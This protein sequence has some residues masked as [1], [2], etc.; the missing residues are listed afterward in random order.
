MS[1]LVAME[2]QAERGQHADLQWFYYHM[3][4]ADSTVMSAV[5]RRLAF[6]DSLDWEIRLV[7][8]ADPVLAQEQALALREAYD[9][10]DNLKDAARHLATALFRGYAHLDKYPSGWGRRVAHL[11]PVPQWLWVRRLPDG[12]WLYNP[13][14][15]SCPSRAQP[16]DR[17]TLMIHAA[18]AL[19]RNIARHFFSKTLAFADWDTALENSANQSIFVVGP[20][21]VPAD[22][23]EE[24][25]S[26]AERITSDGRGY[27]PNGSD[28][29]TVDLFARSKLPFLDR[30]DYCDRQIVLAATGGLLTMLTESGSGT[31][32]GGAHS[33]SLMDLARSD[34]ARLSETFQRDL[35]KEVLHAEF[36]HQPV[37]AYFAFDV[38]QQQDPVALLQAIGNLSWQGYRAKLDWLQE[39]TGMQMELMPQPGGQ[40]PAPTDPTQGVSP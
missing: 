27:L 30:I 21:G 24:Y 25:K 3:E 16:V 17:R 2:D 38:P 5:A 20:P 13:D 33:Q 4:K 23:Q 10:I 11:E 37:A 1:R 31:L 34:A 32:A 19:Y 18:P 9:R 35:D 8:S 7:E 22:K 26:V 6:I 28:I 29:K 15:N 36:P 39:K 14:A 12:G 40:A